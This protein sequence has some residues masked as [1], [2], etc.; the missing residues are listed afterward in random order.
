[1]FSLIE[2]NI[3]LYIKKSIFAVKVYLTIQSN[4]TIANVSGMEDFYNT[5]LN[6]SIKPNIFTTTLLQVISG[7]TTSYVVFVDVPLNTPYGT[8]VLRASISP[9]GISKKYLWDQTFSIIAYEEYIKS[10]T[11]IYFSNG[12]YAGQY[13]GIPIIRE[14]KT[15]IINNYNGTRNW[16]VEYDDAINDLQNYNSFGGANLLSK[17]HELKTSSIGI[18]YSEDNS[19]TKGITEKSHN[20]D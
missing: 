11:V 3:K 20:L 14:G 10:I 7:K 13:G 4:F 15:W 5:T 1:M 2:N 8:E 16:V 9:Q 18:H 6:N 17:I 12:Y 19:H